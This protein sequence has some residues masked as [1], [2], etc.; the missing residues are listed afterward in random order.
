VTFNFIGQMH[1]LKL[2]QK[3][4]MFSIETDNWI[5]LT[6]TV[7]RIRNIKKLTIIGVREFLKSF[8]HVK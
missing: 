1:A 5:V 8:L 2:G 4:R 7:S 6:N 3:E